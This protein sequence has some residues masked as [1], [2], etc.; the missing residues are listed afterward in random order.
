[1]IEILEKANIELLNRIVR[2]MI[3]YLHTNQVGEI[4]SLLRELSP[5]NEQEDAEGTLYQNMPNPKLGH[6]RLRSFA[7]RLFELAEQRLS[8]TQVSEQINLWLAQERTRFLAMAVER[9]NT[10]FKEMRQ[11]IKRFMRIPRG[12]SYLSPDEFVNIRV[13]L[14]R[15][16]LSSDLHYINCAKHVI[17]VID[18]DHIIDR[19]IGIPGGT[20]KLGGKS[21]GMILAYNVLRDAQTQHP[22]LKDIRI[23]ASWFI[24]SDVLL[25]FIHH[26]ALEELTSLKYMD[27]EQVRAGY[28]YLQQ[29]FKNAEFPADIISRLERVLDEAGTR[30]LI[31]RSSSLLEDSFEGAFSGKYKSLFL[32]NQGPREDRLSALCD[33]IAEVYASVFGPDPIEY[34][35]ERGLLDF[36]EEMGVLIQEVVGTRI[37]DHFLPT[38]AGVAFSHNEFRWSPRISREDGVVRLVAGLGTRAVDRIGNDY[39]LL[40]CPG[41]PGLR[42]NQRYEDVLR[43]S[44]HR[45]DALNLKTNEFE[46]LDAETLFREHGTAIP[47]LEQIVSFD[48]Q[49]SL[50]S[51]VGHLMDT[52]EEMIL[53]FE[54]LTTRSGF[55]SRIHL[56]LRI[57]RESM[58]TPVDVE[59]ASDGQSLYLLQCRPQSL[60]ARNEQVALPAHPAPESVLFEANRYVTTGHVNNVLT[61]VHVVPE[62]Y[63]KL[64][65]LEEMK[66]VGRIV[67]RLNS[68]LPRRSFILIGPGR[69]GSRGDIKL[70][71]QVT[72][73]DI[74]RSAMLI[75]VA[76]AKDGYVP[77]LSFGT[78]F[79]QDLVEADIKYLPLY[80]QEEGSSLARSFLE[81]GVNH[82]TRFLPEAEA[83][84]HVV[85]VIHLPWLDT[86]SQVEVLLDG[87]E[88]RGLALIRPAIPKPPEEGKDVLR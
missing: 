9:D 73:S 17:K 38:W 64:E 63:G 76:I 39:S 34:R 44:Q 29:I 79:F 45:L 50:S 62:A 2:R 53:T 6:D 5:D 36:Q 42:V 1:M 10:P 51:P 82:L 60:A 80:P 16:F 4:G 59:F 12:E 74:N 13:G 8:E 69:W 22:E 88:S 75:E 21:A 28:P 18:F 65:T 55:L 30:P 7:E 48:R 67:S 81:D 11:V 32:A 41:K 26:N 49:G 86:P 23:P 33:A 58:K 68:L 25:D 47:G 31:V 52:R 70:G 37:G 83:L 56:L 72:Y 66:E 54:N 46:T 43:Y 71:V 87:E 19:I 3:Y 85:R 14:I 27:A 24:T 35:K 20:G 61:V 57:L 84:A 77:E 15:R 78:H 40:A